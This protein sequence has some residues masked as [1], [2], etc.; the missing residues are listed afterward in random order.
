MERIEEVGVAQQEADRPFGGYHVPETGE[1]QEGQARRRFFYRGGG[2]LALQVKKTARRDVSANAARR[3]SVMHT[4]K[5]DKPASNQAADSGQAPH[6]LPMSCLRED[7]IPSHPNVPSG[8]IVEPPAVAPSRP[9]LTISEASVL[10]CVSPYDTSYIDGTISSDNDSV[11]SR[12]Y[13]IQRNLNQD[14]V[15]ATIVTER[16]SQAHDP[17]PVD[18][19]TLDEETKEDTASPGTARCRDPAVSISGSTY[20]SL[21]S[22]G[23]NDEG[24][25]RNSDELTGDGEYLFG[26][27]D[28]GPT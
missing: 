6:M 3:R 10:R 26:L 27:D 13:Q 8:A 17:E 2:A 9:E 28:D 23:D 5:S 4:A 20:T 18:A 1:D 7:V 22:D 21:D 12:D 15:E 16:Q 19:S 24:T 14:F 25:G 11:N